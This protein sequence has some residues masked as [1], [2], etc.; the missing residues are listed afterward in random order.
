MLHRWIKLCVVC[1][2]LV[3]M[4]TA[5]AKRPA[6]APTPATA[7]VDYVAAP[8]DSYDWKLR[9]SGKFAQGS[10]VELT[11]TSQTWRDQ[12]WRHQL[13]IYR[14]SKVTPTAG[15]L[16]LINGGSWNDSLARPAAEGNHNLP[17]ETVLIA[18]VAE[19]LQ[20]PVAILCQVPEQPLFDGLREDAAISYTFTKFVETGDVDWPLLLPMVKSAVRAMDAVEEFAGQQWELDIDTFLITG[21]SKRGWTT[22]LT[23]AVD[24]RVSALAPLVINMLNMEPHMELQ[25][26]SFGGL[27]DEIRDYTERGMH[28][29]MKSPRGVALRTIV[30]P[31][32][33]LQ[34]I[35]QPKLII[36]GTNDRYWPVD[37]LN[38]YWNA[39]AGEK[40]ILYV[41]NNGH[42]ITD[43]PRVIGAIAALYRSA[44]VEGA[45]PKFDWQFDE[46]QD[47]VRLQLSLEDEP[48]EVV[49]WSA[50]SPTRDFRT[51]RWTSQAAA[52][53]GKQSYS[54]K[55]PRP[56]EGYA[57]L[58]A[59]VKFPGEPLPVHLSSGLRVVEPVSPSSLP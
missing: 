37:S 20:T 21:A 17:S 54:I 2:T 48:L 40:H 42:D 53:N 44:C 25:Q 18:Q 30:D 22:W 28:K 11:L 10:Y 5:V 3:A 50:K 6:A 4:R 49:A 35:S 9:R 26:A 57:A 7:L 39:L 19:A 23:A 41:P 46:E 36:L 45:M 33:Y 38:L 8:D 59:E 56:S 13:Y 43:Y 1:L 14:P 34:Q 55:F 29:L 27:S 31:Y 51:S 58:F 12:K 52:A 16:M 24:P 47:T 32:S 15:A